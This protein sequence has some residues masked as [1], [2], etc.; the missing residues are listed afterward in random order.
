MSDQICMDDGFISRAATQVPRTGHALYRTIGETVRLSLPIILSRTGFLL[1]FVTDTLF[2]GWSG[3]SDLAAIGLG[4]ALM[5]TLL[6][7]GVGATGAIGVLI[8][9]SLGSRRPHLCGPLLVNGLI[10]VLVLGL[11][12]M[13]IGFLSDLVFHVTGQDPALAQ[14]AYDIAWHFAWG[15][16]GMLVFVSL[17][18]FLE[19]TKRPGLGCLLFLAASLANLPANALVSLGWGG[20]VAP[21]GAEGA[22]ITSSALRWL[23]ALALLVI[24]IRREHRQGDPYHIVQAFR[25]L[26][27][28]IKDSLGSKGRVLRHMGLPMGLTQGVESAAFTALVFFAGYL[29]KA[30]VA[31]HEITIT[32]TS[33]IFMIALGISIA[34]SIKAGTAKGQENRAEAGQSGLAGLILAIL[35]TLPFAICLIAFDHVIANAF[36]KDVAIHRLACHGLNLA[37]LLLLIDAVM[38]TLMGALRGL[39]DVWPPFLIQVTTYWGIA[40]PSAG[41][42]SLVQNYGAVGLFYGM[43]AGTLAS[44]LVLLPRFLSQTRA[45]R[46]P[47]ANSLRSLNCKAESVSV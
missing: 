39:G 7:I 31:A 34:T 14:D 6:L 36:T 22:I 2:A 42:F 44:V 8:A 26:P 15:I 12:L 30:A 16:P 4:S 33:L 27:R 13:S 21:M 46:E 5:I 25:T 37:A 20:L 23:S 24:I 32:I 9:Q 3:A 43:I 1:L 28:Q 17:S 11:I 19:A 29:G 35:A 18:M 38:I 47:D 45:K 41:Y 40:I 10:N